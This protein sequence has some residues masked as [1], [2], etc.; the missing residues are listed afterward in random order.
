[1]NKTHAE[2]SFGPQTSP[3]IHVGQDDGAVAGTRL[4]NTRSQRI[5]R[6]A[7]LHEGMGLQTLIVFVTFKRRLLLSVALLNQSQYL[8]F[9][10]P[11]AHCLAIKFTYP[12]LSTSCPPCQ[13]RNPPAV[14]CTA[15]EYPQ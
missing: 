5:P 9:I 6:S 1:M 7:S 13:R 11:I 15:P 2:R 14:G 3:P 4:Q 12:A 8:E 10:Q